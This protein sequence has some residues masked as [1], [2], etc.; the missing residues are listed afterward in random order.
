MLNMFVVTDGSLGR[1]KADCLEPKRR[2]SV[3]HEATRRLWR[4][5]ELYSEP[6]RKGRLPISKP[7]FFANVRNRFYPPGRKISPNIR[8][9]T[10]EEVEA[11]EKGEAI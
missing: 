1:H 9:W 8:A 11:M 2:Q 6:G 7:T 4:A 10:N 3:Q 5:K